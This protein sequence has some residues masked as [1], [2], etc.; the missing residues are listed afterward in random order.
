MLGFGL[1]DRLLLVTTSEGMAAGAVE[2][3]FWDREDDAFGQFFLAHADAVH[4]SCYLLVGKADT[5]EDLLAETFLR[6][7]NRRPHIPA[8]D[9]AA[10]RWLLCVAKNLA[11]DQ[12][13]R[14]R[15]HQLVLNLVGRRA[16]VP[17]RHPEDEVVERS[18]LEAVL[19]ALAELST[20]D[21]TLIALRV[22]GGLSF[23]EIATLMGSSVAAVQM[24]LQ[25]AR[26]RLRSRCVIDWED[27]S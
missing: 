7:Y 24:G 20:R 14:A 3:R 8:D 19:A 23:A 27:R 22:G 1:P 13:R 4:R 10:R 26:S 17:A 15:R 2:P 11:V 5:A 21:R 25:R 6:A 18:E 16:A 9:A 12:Y